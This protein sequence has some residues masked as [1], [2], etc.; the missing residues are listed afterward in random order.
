MDVYFSHG[1]ER[2]IRNSA[3]RWPRSSTPLHL[4]DVEQT[5]AAFYLQLQ[6][7]TRTKMMQHVRADWHR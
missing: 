2:P 6:W 3:W 5:E 4:G 7:E 1:Q